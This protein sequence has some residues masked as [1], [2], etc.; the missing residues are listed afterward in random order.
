MK[1]SELKPCSNCNGPLLGKQLINWYVVRV[2]MA[3][4]HPTNARETLGLMQYFGG[5]LAIAEAMAP[6]ADESVA[7]I[8][9]QPGASWSELHLCLDCYCTVSVC[10]LAALIERQSEGAP[11]A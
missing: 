8:A 10:S 5:A 11:A 7:I 4:L 1:L 9:D 6:R 3:M 2:S